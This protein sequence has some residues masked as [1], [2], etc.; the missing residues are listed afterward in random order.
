[1]LNSRPKSGSTANVGYLP[2]FARAFLSF[3]EGSA[4]SDKQA[5]GIALFAAAAGIALI[6]YGFWSR[7][8]GAV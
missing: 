3:K 5:A 8:A 2:S 1:M 7:Y 6:V 4:M